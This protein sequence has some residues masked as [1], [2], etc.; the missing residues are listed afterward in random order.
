[1]GKSLSILKRVRQNEKKRQRNLDYKLKIKKSK[2]AIQKAM[3]SSEVNKEELMKLYNQ[4][5][6]E[7]DKAVKKNVIH[8]RNAARKKSRMN[9]AIK[10]SLAKKS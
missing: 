7:V 8:K 3:E 4:F 1:M 6:S 9:A 2:K 5:A 10:K